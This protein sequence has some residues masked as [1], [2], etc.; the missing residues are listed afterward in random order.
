MR[1]LE[2]ADSD[3]FPVRRLI[4]RRAFSSGPRRGMRSSWLP[5]RRL[6]TREGPHIVLCPFRARR[7]PIHANT[8]VV[9]C[10]QGGSVDLREAERLE[11][12]I[13]AGPA[14]SQLQILVG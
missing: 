2:R 1:R 10:C 5:I 8:Q 6:E 12:V 3:L 4:E 9:R 7:R 13:F 14:N 11:A